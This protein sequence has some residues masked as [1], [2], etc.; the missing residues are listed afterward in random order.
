LSSDT[1]QNIVVGIIIGALVT[2]F[3]WLLQAIP[4]WGEKKALAKK[5]RRLAY[6]RLKAILDGL[7]N[8]GPSTNKR[9]YSE[10]LKELE[11]IVA[12]YQEVLDNSTIETWYSKKIIG[13]TALK[14]EHAEHCIVDFGAFIDNVRWHYERFDKRNPSHHLAYVMNSRE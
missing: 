10:Q 2:A 7:P 4:S 13:D 14:E 6:T 8:V 11:D 5:R 9:V 3:G 1:L 12:E